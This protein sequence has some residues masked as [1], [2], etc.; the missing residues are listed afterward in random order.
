MSDTRHEWGLDPHDLQRFL[1]AQ[2]HDYPQ[3][4]AE[5]R[6]GRKRSHWM[7]FIF[8]Q[9]HGLG[10]SPT[11][12]H[13]GIKS[14]AEAVAYLQHPELGSRLTTCAEAVMA[15]EGAS[16][17]EIFGSPDDLKLRSS[18]TLFARVA[19]PGSVFERLLEKYF[20]GQPDPRTGKS[21]SGSLVGAHSQ[22]WRGL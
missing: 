6:Q 20:A 14:R 16:A 9:I 4:L 8:P 15:I 11:A 19:V 3:A 1:Q 5:L 17:A 13:Y 2:A 7:W 21:L 22:G 18:A 12:R 10:F